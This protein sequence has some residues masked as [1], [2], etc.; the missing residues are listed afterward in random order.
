LLKAIVK[1][2]HQ[3]ILTEEYIAEAQR[4]SIAQNMALKWMYQMWW[5]QWVARI[6]IVGFII[7]S[8]MNHIVSTAA[9]FGVFLAISFLGEWFG[10]R[11]LAKARDNVRAKGSTTVVSMSEQGV[12]ID[13]ALGN[14]HLK[15]PAMLQPTIYPQGVL[16][17]LSRLSAMWLPDET[18][19]EGSPAD[20]RQLL[21][22]NIDKSNIDGK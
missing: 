19:I 22:R 20:V 9:L 1:T 6:I 17:R 14:S 3:I 12:D 10:R 8:L 5:V 11:N 4:F 2:T 7:Y 21:A 16:M 13:G 18:L 15:W